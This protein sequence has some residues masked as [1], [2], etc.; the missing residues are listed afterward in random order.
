MTGVEEGC[1]DPWEVWRPEHWASS[2]CLP[3]PGMG[4]PASSDSCLGFV[5]SA[6]KAEGQSQIRISMWIIFATQFPGFKFLSS[7]LPCPWTLSC[8]KAGTSTS[9]VH[10]K[11]LTLQMK[12]QG[13]GH[14]RG[15]CQPPLGPVPADSTLARPLCGAICLRRHWLWQ[16]SSPDTE[17]LNPADLISVLFFLDQED[18]WRRKW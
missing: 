13:G 7:S 3:P 12:T 5:T 8:A 16:A 11:P 2:I 14:V 9:G 17:G 4:T 15:L 1:C 18:P 6:T 10:C